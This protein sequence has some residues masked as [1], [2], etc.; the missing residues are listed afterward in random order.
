MSTGNVRVD[1]NLIPPPELLFDGSSSPD[2]FVRFGDGFVNGILLR[3]GYLAPSWAIL[4]VGCGNGSVA[5][6][7]TSVLDAQGR[8][9]GIDVSASTIAWLQDRYRLYTNFH[10]THSDVFNKMYNPGGSQ[11]AREYRFPFEADRFNTVVLKSVFTH[12]LPDEVHAY[13]REIARVLRPSGRAVISYF[14]L[15]EESRRLI[16][17]GA[18]RLRMP[19]EIPGDPLCRVATPAV[20]E[21]AVA[22]DEARIRAYYA[23]VGLSVSEI[24]YGDWCGRPTM[25]GL[26]DLVVA[27]KS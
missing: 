10:F 6:A 13:L 18:D 2:E 23:G 19:F 27:T 25:I 17:R 26:Q 7:L 20:P 1:A 16:A 4:D 24:V 14:L 21:E 9:E 5:R 22:H 11:A 15:N 3:R 12:M 8:Y